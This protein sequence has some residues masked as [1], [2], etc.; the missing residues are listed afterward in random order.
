M[1]V[2]ATESERLPLLSTVSRRMYGAMDLDIITHVDVPPGMCAGMQ[3]KWT[4]DNFLESLDLERCRSSLEV[5]PR[6]CSG[7]AYRSGSC[8]AWVS[9]MRSARHEKCEY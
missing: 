3:Y 5:T 2:G 1:L 9:G 8:A 6:G 4:A 7:R